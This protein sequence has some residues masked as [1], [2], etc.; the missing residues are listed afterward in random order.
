MTI[1][2][3][4]PV[5]ISKLTSQQVEHVTC[6]EC[7]KYY[8]APETATCGHTLCHACWKGRRAC[9]TCAAPVEKKALKLNL[10]L[11]ALTEHIH[12]L[13]DAFE[14]L[15]SVKLEEFTLDILD[16]LQTEDPTKHVKEW[17]ANSD[18]HFS[19]PAASS[20]AS[21]VEL[22]QHMELSKSK[23]Q[24]HTPNNKTDSPETSKIVKLPQPQKD[25]DKI[26]VLP[27]TEVPEKPIDHVVGPMDIEPFFFDEN[28]Y[29][30]DHPRRSSRKKDLKADCNPPTYDLSVDKN[31]AKNSSA[32][33]KSL[34]NKQTWNSV[35]KMRKEFGKLNKKNKSKLNVSIEMCKKAQNTAKQKQAQTLPQNDSEKQHIVIDDETPH[36]SNKNTSMN[37]SRKYANENNEPPEFEIA[38]NN[39][40][41][42][43]TEEF[44]E[45]FNE[46]NLG[47]NKQSNEK[48]EDI[49]ELNHMNVQDENGE[50]SKGKSFTDL[51]KSNKPMQNSSAGTNLPFIKKGALH[52]SSMPKKSDVLI[53]QKEVE[54]DTLP[55]N[56]D[57][58]EI[59][60]KI[61]NTVTNIVIKHK[62]NYVQMKVNTDREIQTSLGPYNL[63]NKCDA[64]CSPMSSANVQNI[65]LNIDENNKVAVNKT[66]SSKKNTAS[67]DT[68][69]VP[70]AATNFE[71][72]DSIDRELSDVMEHLERKRNQ[73]G[74]TQKK[75]QC[76]KPPL[77]TKTS[78]KSVKDTPNKNE[79]IDDDRNEEHKI[80]TPH[81]K[82]QNKITAEV[83]NV[84]KEME[85][86]EDLND[87]DIFNSGSVKEAN[88]KLLQETKH[89]ASEI[90]LPTMKSKK[91]QKVADKRERA[92]N[93]DIDL[94]SSKK[95]K[96]IS[97]DIH[98]ETNSLVVVEQHDNVSH[99]ESMNYDAI[100]SQVFANIDADIHNSHKKQIG[101]TQVL[102][103][104]SNESQHSSKGSHLQSSQIIQ[105]TQNKPPRK[106]ISPIKIDGN[107]E[108]VNQKYSENVFSIVEKESQ[109]HEATGKKNKF[110]SSSDTQQRIAA[111]LT[112]SARR[113]LAAARDREEHDTELDKD[114][115]MVEL[116]HAT[117]VIDN[118]D[119]ESV[120]EETPQ[121]NI[122][123]AKPKQN[124]EMAKQVTENK[125]NLVA[126]KKPDD[127][128]TDSQII[129]SIIDISDTTI[130]PSK[131]DTTVVE[132]GKK[133]VSLSR[134]SK[135]QVPETPLTIN[136]FVN[137]IKH[138]STPMARKS[139][140]FDSEIADDPEQTLCPTTTQEKE[141][142]SEAFKQTQVS[143]I[144]KALT[145]KN[146]FNRPA[147]K[148]FVAGSC[149]TTAESW[150]LKT[151]CQERGWTFL[152]KYTSELTHLV[153]GVDEE[154]K[155]QRS[156]KYMCALA[157]SKWI[158]K[159]AWVERCLLNKTVVD[160]FP[161]EALDACGA[162]G[163]RRSR[164]A[165]KKV[166]D[167][168]TFYC[169]PPFSLLD[170]DTLKQMLRAAGGAVSESPADVKLAAPSARPKL[171]LVEPE[172][173]Q[174][175]KFVYF[176]M[177]H[178]VVPV[179]FEWA[180]NCLGS[181]SLCSIRDLLL[182]PFAV[183]PPAV[184]A[185]PTEMLK[186][187]EEL[188]DED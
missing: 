102:K 137:H 4:D 168:I 98:I 105:K 181:Y 117:P 104:K 31:S 182:C 42:I 28:D 84:N 170:I 172:S 185:W 2:G 103:Q 166:F 174:E 138:N 44:P 76:T 20:Q 111:L 144:K 87:M 64:E 51:D 47:P 146:I 161:Y 133:K 24:I 73:T 48:N 119:S 147:K 34:K 154:D 162:P 152:D 57:D 80:N 176:A 15:F 75:T 29:S 177:E 158:V 22:P 124:N 18:N 186:E 17:L 1:E 128:E 30:N 120:V 180:L 175:D 171:L 183:L 151:L 169:M 100:M 110:P 86:I 143:P 85:G 78:Q 108:V 10:P 53:T 27:D 130:E 60:I 129:R 115:E 118:D 67:A 56:T 122:S 66:I 116:I 43:G 36:A 184:K 97:D 74:V 125:Q 148:Y 165:I 131:K 49:L 89:I 45:V 93:D 46:R 109:T 25:W 123:F 136:K 173:T 21:V 62:K 99:S 8:I 61:G 54:T 19:A 68:A 145:L 37:E 150:K 41:N 142:L 92:V 59:S 114:V 71:I 112:P 12:T 52:Q 96:I 127:K 179:N 11:Q 160:E 77:S 178:Q 155:S 3:L 187:S 50:K 7:C 159:Y 113:D 140:H 82:S 156:V 9:H 38:L 106:D 163:P 72:T 55:T 40:E 13:A 132:M 188:D 26:E 65:E 167:G 14:K 135:E 35:K 91:S 83:E 153:V 134:S 32:G 126:D 101:K 70:T 107:T 95:Q 5:I 149:L 88:V 16:D 33:T 6:I 63:E 139:L 69:T 90:L 81:E 121:K 58:I 164:T 23:I 141:F 94:P 79:L 157:A 39:I